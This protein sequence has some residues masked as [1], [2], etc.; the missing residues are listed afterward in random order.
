MVEER[1]REVRVGRGHA[2]E[3]RNTDRRIGVGGIVDLEV[4]D[5]LV[6]PGPAGIDQAVDDALRALTATGLAE[7]T[8]HEDLLA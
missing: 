8:P 6:D 5:V 1:G 3:G 4:D 7:Q 2:D